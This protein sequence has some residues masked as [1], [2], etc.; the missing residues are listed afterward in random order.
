LHAALQKAMDDG[1]VQVFCSPMTRARQ[2]LAAFHAEP[3]QPLSLSGTTFHF[4]DDMIEYSAET[5]ENTTAFVDQIYRLF[6]VLQKKATIAV[7]PQT[8]LLFGHSLAFSTLL[9]M[10]ATHRRGITAEEHRA[11]VLHRVA[12]KEKP[13]F[14]ETV[15]Q[16]PNCSISVAQALQRWEAKEGKKEATAS[17]LEWSI[18]GVAKCQHLSQL[19][20]ATGTKSDF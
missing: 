9:T 10:F 5:H 6:C 1:F 17:S 4:L 12:N 16:L 3:T 15:Y 14:L 8:I 19:N 11:L 20:L 2:T 7:E 18:L 13:S